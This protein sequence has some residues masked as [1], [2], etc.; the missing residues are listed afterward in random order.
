MPNVSGFMV[1]WAMMYRLAEAAYNR[2]TSDPREAISCI[3]LSAIGFEAFF[4]EF[5]ERAGKAEASEPDSVKVFYSVGSRMEQQ[6]AS[7][8][9]KLEIA[10]FTFRGREIARGNRPFQDFQLLVVLRNALVHQKPEIMTIDWLGE[11]DPEEHKL[12]TA[13]S[14]RGLIKKP[15]TGQGNQLLRN[16]S[17]AKLARWAYN[18]SVSMTHLLTKI[19]PAG[20]FEYSIRFLTRQL[21]LLKGDT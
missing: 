13:L 4:N 10:Y 15:P 1:S 20:D 18:V 14:S 3:I 17:N 12:V 6:H 19:L 9:A 16:V 11:D 8:L 5:L 7:L 21:E 2:S